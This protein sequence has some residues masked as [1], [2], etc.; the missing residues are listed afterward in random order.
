MTLM[1]AAIVDDEPMARV[2]L[3]RLLDRVGRDLVSVVAECVDIGELSAVAVNLDIDVLFLDI[4]MPG[5]DGFQALARWPGPRPQVVFVTAFP[6]HGARAFDVRAV[7]YLIKPVSGERLRDTLER[8]SGTR[9][10][11]GVVN[12]VVGDADRIPLKVGSR[13][14][15]V[16]ANKIDLVVSIGNYLEV[17]ADGAVYTVRGTLTDFHSRLGHVEFARLHRS[18]V[19]RIAAIR[20]I[21]PAGSARFRIVLLSGQHLFSGRQFRSKVDELLV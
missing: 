21:V 15:L 6:Q 5:G 2:R 9:P 16:Q 17:H 12:E 20:Q 10:K 4:E 18:A 7:D 11:D 8:L 13:V 19:V 14:H 1:R 3:R